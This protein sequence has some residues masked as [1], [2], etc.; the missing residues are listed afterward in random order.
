MAETHILMDRPNNHRCLWCNEPYRYR[1]TGGRAQRFCS[2]DCRVEFFSAA[3]QWAIEAIERGELTVDQIRNAPGAAFTL[4]TER[5][6]VVRHLGHP[7][8]RADSVRRLPTATG[9]SA[10]PGEAG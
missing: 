7:K 3:R 5:S 1:S 2:S 4:V 10:L 9:E 6:R 8:P